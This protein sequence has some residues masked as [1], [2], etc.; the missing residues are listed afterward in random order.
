MT[1]LPR[2]GAMDRGCGCGLKQHRGREAAEIAR[3]KAVRLALPGTDPGRLRLRECRR[4]PGIWHL[5][6]AEEETG[7]S[8]AVKL[9]V[10]TR[11]GNGD[12]GMALCEAC[13]CW[14]GTHAGEYQHRL[15]RG[16]GG[17]RLAVVN[18]PANAALLCGSG[19]LRTGDHGLCENRDRDMHGMGFWLSYGQDPRL[20][21]VMLHGRGGGGTT[22]WLADDGL[23]E[24]GS[25][26]LTAPPRGL[27]AA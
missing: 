11:A 10:R 19:A 27:V 21:P 4:R 24:D 6:A 8:D 12:P 18:G 3:D 15:A 9:L 13:G 5:A 26:Y 7:F 1:G 22:V 20:E 23:G 2:Y 16:I 14:L 17:C 25:G